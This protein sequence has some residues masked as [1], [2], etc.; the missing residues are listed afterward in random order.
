MEGTFAPRNEASQD[1]LLLQQIHRYLERMDAATENIASSED[2]YCCA[3]RHAARQAMI[4]LGDY[5]GARLEQA[6]D[7]VAAGAGPG[8]PDQDMR[9]AA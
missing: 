9:P 1:R 7:G 8:L 3:A 2:E 6:Q 4:L 5:I